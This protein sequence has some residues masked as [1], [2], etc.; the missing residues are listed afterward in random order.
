MTAAYRF[1]LQM[2]VNTYGGAAW[3]MARRPEVEE[4]AV[5]CIAMLDLCI[6]LLPLAC[7]GG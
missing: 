3:D 6:Y 4:L 2:E 1:M 5:C 7:V